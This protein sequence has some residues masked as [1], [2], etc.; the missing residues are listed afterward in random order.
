MYSASFVPFQSFGKITSFAWGV[1]A[2]PVPPT[3]P[4]RNTLYPDQWSIFSGQEHPDQ[5]WQLM[6]YMVSPAGLKVYPT[7]TGALPSRRSV[8]GDWKQ[9]V[10]GYTKL[11]DAD[12]NTTIAA[13][14][15]V[16]VVPSHAMVNFGDI[17]SKGVA[18]T[19][20]KLTANQISASTVPR[21]YDA[22]GADAAEELSIRT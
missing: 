15:H 17:Y 19:I 1:A 14:D 6:A 2:M 3:L 7:K 12:L 4:P 5:A 8:T 11:T 16:Q 22:G 20:D 10:Q 13:A 21:H 18:P 9:I